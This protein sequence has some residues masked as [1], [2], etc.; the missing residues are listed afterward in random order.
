MTPFRSLIKWRTQQVLV[1]VLRESMLEKIAFFSRRSLEKAIHSALWSSLN[2]VTHTRH[3][4]V[5][6]LEVRGFIIH[7]D[8]TEDFVDCLHH[9]TVALLC[10]DRR[11]RRQFR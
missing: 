5:I 11:F 6:Y 7:L 1:H 8:M 9:E 10:R 2:C 4:T 3:N